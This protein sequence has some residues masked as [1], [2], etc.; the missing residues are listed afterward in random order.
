MSDALKK[1]DFYVVV[2]VMQ[3]ADMNYA[4]I[5][6]PVAS[7]YEVDHPFELFENW[8]MARN[9]VIEPLGDYKSDYEFWFELAVRMGYGNDFW[10]GSLTDC[11]NDQLGPF[12]ITLD[13]LRA[14]PTGIVVRTSRAGVREI[15]A[16]FR[17][18]EHPALAGAFS[19][20]RKSRH[21]QHHI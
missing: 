19:A 1:L 18:P 13:E 8:L 11:M 14:H 10:N 17:D 7:M 20:A 21:L 2:D 4:D 15:R 12:G 9:K 16:G 6:I 5:V 3:T